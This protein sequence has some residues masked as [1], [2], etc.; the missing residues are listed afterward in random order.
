MQS[1]SHL[2]VLIP[3][4]G[5]AGFVSG[6]AGFAFSGAAAVILLV[7]PPQEAVPLL[8]CLSIANQTVS[9]SLLWR[10]MRILPGAD[11]AEVALPY[12]LGGLLGAPVGLEL[13]YRLPASTMSNLFGGLLILFALVMLALPVLPRIAATGSVSAILTGWLG[14]VVGGFSAFPGAIPAVFLALRRTS[15]TETRGA[16]QPYLLGMQ[17]CHSGGGG[18]RL[19]G[20]GGLRGRGEGGG[21]DSIWFPGWGSSEA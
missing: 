12:L 16:L 18:G 19:S 14:G 13:L 20:M 9:V 15:K 21:G 17:C 1:L 4:L 7:L 6:L 8:I 11:G 5:L 2:T 10:H 3:I